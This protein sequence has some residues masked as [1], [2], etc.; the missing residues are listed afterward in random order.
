[1]TV[2]DPAPPAGDV[3]ASPAPLLDDATRADV[4]VRTVSRRRRFLDRAAAGGL[5]TAL[6]I[7]V[8]PLVSVVIVLI[9]KGGSMLSW[10]FLTGDIPAVTG[11]TTASCQGITEAFRVKYHMNCAAPRPPWAR[12]S[13]AP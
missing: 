1:M 6:V 4:R 12:P 3:G 2:L 11:Q 9:T 13:S 7:A 10:H 5:W 8:I